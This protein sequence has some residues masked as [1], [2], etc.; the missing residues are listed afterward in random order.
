[1]QIGCSHASAKGGRLLCLVDNMALCLSVGRS[2]GRSFKLLRILRIIAGWT[3]AFGVSLSVRWVPSENKT[4]DD[5]SRSEEKLGQHPHGTSTLTP[6]PHQVQCSARADGLLSASPL[7][8][9]R[10]SMSSKGKNDENIEWSPHG[11]C[12]SLAACCAKSSSSDSS[13]CE[14]EHQKA[15]TDLDASPREEEGKLS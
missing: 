8:P 13:A 5:P 6:S 4:S 2:R 10:S 7:P 11:Q 14:Q 15:R 3:L 12:D 9:L 1:M